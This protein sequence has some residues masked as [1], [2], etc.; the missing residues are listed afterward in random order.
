M[1]FIC[2]CAD[3]FRVGPSIS[4]KC[5]RNVIS[6]NIAREQHELLTQVWA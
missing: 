4:P 5:P 6:W 2:W 3:G 1:E